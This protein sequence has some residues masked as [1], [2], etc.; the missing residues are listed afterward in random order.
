MADHVTNHVAELDAHVQ[1]RLRNAIVAGNTLHL[2]IG[3]SRAGG[4]RKAYDIET[5]TLNQTGTGA[6]GEIGR[7][8]RQRRTVSR[9]NDYR[10][11]A[12]CNTAGI[13]RKCGR[14]S[15]AV[16]TVLNDIAAAAAGHNRAWVEVN[17]P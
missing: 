8:A 17:W 1:V 5:R 13:E 4:S 16:S 7:A 9:L 15:T 2:K 12:T 11:E 10:V 14:E 6:D 3:N